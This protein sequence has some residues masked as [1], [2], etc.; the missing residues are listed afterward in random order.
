MTDE[1]GTDHGPMG[2]AETG[3]EG[4]SSPSSA[5][6]CTPERYP[7]WGYSDLLLFAGLVIP[8]M[9]GGWAIVKVVFAIFHFHPAL[10]VMELLP[11]QLLG[12]GLL[13][14]AFSVALRVQYDRPFWKSVGW[15]P[16]RVPVMW[17]VMLGVVTSLAVAFLGTLIGT[18]TTENPM[19]S[20][21]RKA[22]SIARTPQKPRPDEHTNANRR[23]LH[24]TLTT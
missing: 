4:V 10:K 8:C 13:F 15:T 2:E 1:Q 19:T 24:G 22:L 3:V 21:L 14:G 20:D 5:A 16:L 6:P 18:P 12:Y 9:L 23:A 11:E 7:C 17:I